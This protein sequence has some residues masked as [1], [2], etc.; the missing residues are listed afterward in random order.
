M[1]LMYLP[2][3]LGCIFRAYTQCFFQ[4]AYLSYKASVCVSAGMPVHVSVRA[5][6]LLLR[7]LL[8]MQLLLLMM[9]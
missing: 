8:M 3:S 6:R 7:L 9:R 4:G 1:P 5:S 2:E